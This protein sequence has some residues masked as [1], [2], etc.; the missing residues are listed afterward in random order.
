MSRKHRL[1]QQRRQ[2]FLQELARTGSP[3]AAAAHATPWSTHKQGGVSSFRDHARRDPEFA[4]AWERAVH[5]A[6]AAVEGEI[7][8]RAMSPPKRP[9]W[10]R[11]EVKGWVEDRNSSDKLLLRLAARLDPAWR[12]RTSVDANVTVEASVL[13][14][15]PGDILYL[16]PSE[17][18]LLK[19]LLCKIADAR[20]EQEEHDDANVPR[21]PAP[22]GVGPVTPGP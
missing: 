19:D 17:Q 12:E 22:G 14:I 15:A 7:V 5:H 11:G 16:A 8:R 20:G 13:A 21:L 10:E 1:T 9:V 3:I 18:E 4:A 2:L 6:L